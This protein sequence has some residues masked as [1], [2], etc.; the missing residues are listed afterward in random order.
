[1]LM[2]RTFKRMG[3]VV[4]LLASMFTNASAQGTWTAPAAPGQDLS[5]LA[6]NVN[7]FVYNIEADAILSRGM[8]WGT[9]AVTARLDWGDSRSDVDNCQKARVLKEDGGRILIHIIDRENGRNFGQDESTNPGAMWSDLWSD[10]GDRS[11]FTYAASEKYPNAFVLTN[12]QYNQ[13]VDVL[14]SRGGKATLYGGKGFTDWAFITEADIAAGKLP[15]FK[16]RLAMWKLYQALDKAGKVADNAAALEAA[17][18]VY[19]N[20]E[21]TTNELR[22][23]FRTLFLAVAGSIEDPVDVSYMFTHADIFGD[24]S[25][26][27]WGYTDFAWGVTECEKYHVPFTIEQALTDAPNGL[28]DVTFVG[29]Y[30][31]DEGDTT[32]PALTVTASE[33]GTG[34]MANMETL[35]A[36]WNVG[37]NVQDGNNRYEAGW[38]SS[39]TGRRPNWMFSAGPAQALDEACAKV[40]NVKVKDNNLKVTF[41]VVT[42]SQWVNFQRF[43]ITYKGSINAGL[44]KSLLTKIAEGEAYSNDAVDAKYVN[45]VKE[46][47]N[48]AKSLTANSDEQ[49]LT[50]AINA[51]D[52]AIA[53]AN[54]APLLTNV[55][56]LQATI[57]VASAENVDVTAATAAIENATKN[58]EIEKALT[59]LRTARR[60]NAVDKQ[61]DVFTGSAP[62]NNGQYYLYN[63]GAKRYLTGGVNYGTHAAVN[64]AAQIATFYQNGEG[65]RIHTNIR[66]NSDALNHNGYV[67]CGGDGDT[68]YLIEVEPGV[69]N[70]STVNSNTGATLLGYSGERRGNW[71]QVDTDNEG[72]SLAIN[73]WK[74]VSK[75]ERDALLAQATPNNP[76]DATYYIHAAGFDHHLADASMA[77]PTQKW[78]TWFEEG[79]GGNNGIGGWEP[80]FNW[81]C[82]NAGNIKFYQELTGLPAGRYTLRAQGYYRH[83]NFEQAETEALNGQTKDDGAIL[84]ATNGSNVTKQNNLVPVVSEAGK[85]PG[86]G[87]NSAVGTFPDDRHETVAQ[88][89]EAGLYKNYVNDVI[90]G[91]DG[92]LTIGMEKFENN[93]GREWVVLDNFRLTYLGPVE[94]KSMTVVGDF[95]E[96]GWEPANGVTMTQDS[97]NPAIWTA[98][99]DVTVEGKKYEYK[100]TANG[101][102]GEYELPATGNYDFVFGTQEYPAGD[103]RLVF[104]ADT[105]NHTLTLEVLARKSLTLDENA[106]ELIEACPVA[107]VT[108]TRAF[109][110]GWNAVVLPFDTE[111]FDG[112]QVAEF[113]KEEIDGE[114]NVTL[115]FKKAT[116]IKANVPYLIYF[117]AAVAGNKVFNEVNVQPAEVKVEAEHFDFVGTHVKAAV[118]KAGDYVISGGKLSKAEDAIELLGGHTFFQ[119][120]NTAGVRSVNIS[121]GD[122]ITTGISTVNAPM[123]TAKQVYN[124]QGQKVSTTSKGIFIENGKKVIK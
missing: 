115:C 109:N 20:A 84:Y 62:E 4:L 111:V 7:V 49:T 23:A 98:T 63:I 124:L 39:S 25:A 71:W 104:T 32:P 79:K 64:F 81:E 36:L 53:A 59:D 106:T 29:I 44:Y 72:A 85:V 42:G 103:Y 121:F 34:N 61:E 56:L 47:A 91:P 77:F 65:W 11:R 69:Y 92:K 8:D 67:D 88:F 58:T 86:Y 68:W 46:A 90:V 41:K 35:G 38:A 45:A 60:L 2:K 24:Q 40:E 112:A 31:Q 118:V 27:G 123:T 12:V 80:D 105:Q 100:A 113:D 89:F 114:G 14:W 3:G 107:N 55:A 21:A 17:N 120:K 101:V 16:A 19:T 43:F 50:D 57:E 22:A 102:W 116:E 5:T 108:V 75:A 9:K 99:K 13:P 51:I 93:Q 33:G 10:T 73:Q 76:F 117:D 15:Q 82:W 48:N 74:L 78:Q 119:A 26:E 95:D 122:D 70:I 37:G 54:E 110:A 18:S 96:I 1:M 97:E 30:R 83:G 52:A 94:I 87:R 28:Y 6:D 66:T